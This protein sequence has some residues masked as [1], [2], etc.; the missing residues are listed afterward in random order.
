MGN[1][2]S[3]IFI[4]ILA[5]LLLFIYPLLHMYQQLDC[6]TRIFVYT[7]TTKLVDSVRNI[8]YLTP[9]MYEEFTEKLAAT[10]NSYIINLEHRHLK[11]DPIYGDPM[12][13]SSFENDFNI[14]YS[15]YYTKDIMKILFPDDG[16]RQEKYDFTQGDYFLVKV[17][18][19]NKTFATKVMELLLGRGLPTEVI[20]VQYGGMIK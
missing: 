2:L 8:G 16:S 12:D 14:N 17:V 20:L 4:I 18:N 13:E 3:K 9:Q 11:Y 15:A 5:L 1:A 7:E 6:N 19:R 10:N